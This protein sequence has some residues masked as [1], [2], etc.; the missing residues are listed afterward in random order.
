MA[1]IA[2][3]PQATLSPVG[4]ARRKIAEE[5]RRRMAPRRAMT[6]RRGIVSPS[7]HPLLPLPSPRRIS[8]SAPARTTRMIIVYGFTCDLTRKTLDRKRAEL[9]QIRHKSIDAVD[10]ECNL[11]EPNSMTYDIWRRLVSSGKLLEPTSFVRKIM[12]K[13]CDALGRGERVVLVGHSYGGSVASRVGMFLK[14]FCPAADLSRLE[15]L[16]LGSIFVPPPE[17]TQGIRIKHVA[18]SNDVA[19]VCSKAGCETELIP[20]RKRDPVMSH[21]NYAHIIERVAR[22]GRM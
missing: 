15:I 14:K 17:T 10:V 18:Y 21:L 20:P 22:T 6:A 13:V 5:L 19:R 2:R 11:E 4:L 9:M 7:V 1:V 16:T 3:S 8:N 12:A